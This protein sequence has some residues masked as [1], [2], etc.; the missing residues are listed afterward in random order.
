[1][2]RPVSLETEPKT[3]SEHSYPS[4]EAAPVERTQFLLPDSVGTCDESVLS[5]TLAILTQSFGLGG[6]WLLPQYFI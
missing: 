4:H 6:S 1:M 5:L 3:Y 2:L